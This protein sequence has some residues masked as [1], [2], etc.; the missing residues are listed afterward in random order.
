MKRIEVAVGVLRREHQVLVGQRLVRD[1]YYQKWEFPGGKFESGEE[2]QYALA[3]ELQEELGIQVHNAVP[4]ICLDHD[5]PDRQVRLHVYEIDGFA[6]EPHG[7]EGQAIQWLPVEKCSELDFLQANEPIVNALRLPKSMLIT[8]TSR[9]GGEHTLQCIKRRLDEGLSFFVQIR[10]QGLAENELTEFVNS[11]RE[12]KTAGVIL[13]GDPDLAVRLGCDGVHLPSKAA[14]SYSGRDQLPD[15]WVGMSCHNE[16]ELQLAEAIADYA[17]LS[18]VARTQTHPDAKLLEWSGFSTLA[19]KAKLPCFA[20]GGMS[21][22]DMD[23]AR[24]MGGQGVAMIG[25]AWQASG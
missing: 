11:I 18:P 16:Q 9:F 1:R 24:E 21:M 4:L 5:Y 3:R 15:F 12:L 2:P 7:K 19:A 10:E 25:A 14:L 20:L 8:Q 6:G 13:N 22:S 23:Q 17:L